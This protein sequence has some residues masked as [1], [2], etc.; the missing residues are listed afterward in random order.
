MEKSY[1][2]YYHVDIRKKSIKLLIFNT[3]NDKDLHTYLLTCLVGV[4]NFYHG[5]I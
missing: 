4:E 5:L 2:L 3:I 1:Y